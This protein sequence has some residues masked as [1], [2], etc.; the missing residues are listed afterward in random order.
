M[1]F[2]FLFAYI[3]VVAMNMKRRLVLYPLV[4]GVFMPILYQRWE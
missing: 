4:V 2:C 3:V 1:C